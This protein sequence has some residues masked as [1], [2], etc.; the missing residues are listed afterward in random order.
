MADEQHLQEVQRWTAKRRVGLVL[1]L[2][3][4]RNHAADAARHQSPEVSET[5][6]LE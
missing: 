1:S 6:L 4:W 5:W 3:E 2:R